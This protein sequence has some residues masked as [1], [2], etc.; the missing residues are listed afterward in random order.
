M[1]ERFRSCASCRAS[2]ISYRAF[3]SVGSSFVRST[4]NISLWGTKSNE[5]TP[6]PTAQA[7]PRSSTA[8]DEPVSLLDASERVLQDL[9]ERIP[10]MSGVLSPRLSARALHDLKDRICGSSGALSV[11]SLV[12]FT[13]TLLERE[14]K[15]MLSERAV[16]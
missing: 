12:W 1:I 7:R 10:R 5:S 2:Q 14:L 4:M 13:C 16:T 9:V 6:P 3:G 8:S 15:L 11:V